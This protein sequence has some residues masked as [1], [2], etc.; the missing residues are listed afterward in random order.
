MTNWKQLMWVIFLAPWS[1]ATL[2]HDVPFGADALSQLVENADTIIVAKDA[3]AVQTDRALSDD[4]DRVAMNVYFVGVAEVIAGSVGTGSELRIGVVEGFDPPRV[5]EIK[6]SILFLRQM[7]SEALAKTSM[8]AGSPAYTVVS[9]DYG[10]VGA[11]VPGRTEAVRSYVE[12]RRGRTLGISETLSWAQRHLAS[13]DPFLQRSAIVDLHL[14]NDDPAAVQQLGDALRS[15]LVQLEVK[16]SAIAA[17]E[18]ASGPMAATHLR[19][20]AEN[21]AAQRRLR[22]A[23][24][25]AFRSMPGGGDQLRQWSATADTILAPAASFTLRSIEDLQ[26]R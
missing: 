23:A 4:P 14:S 12:A 11:G 7:S 18:D 3:R 5:D 2:A 16:A 10:I 9:G 21:Q 15:D 6:N 22:E 26:K 8:A 25:K 20:I 1:A 24:V 13:P 17:L 19:T